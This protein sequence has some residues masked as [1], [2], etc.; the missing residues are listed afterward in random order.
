VPRPY[1][2]T[3]R[4]IMNFMDENTQYGGFRKPAWAPPAWLFA[5]VWTL[6]YAIIAW[7][8]G[9]V[10]YS[11][12]TGILLW[13]VSIPFVLNLIFNFAFIPIEFVLK[14][15]AWALVD[16]FLTVGTLIWAMLMVW[17]FWPWVALVNIPYLLWLMFAT[18][19]QATVVAMNRP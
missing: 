13:T 1:L 11:T 19:L 9:V 5:P 7:S 3:T 17:P 15:R 10:F 12:F 8:F 18:V 14:K 4:D 2:D 6:L 16:I